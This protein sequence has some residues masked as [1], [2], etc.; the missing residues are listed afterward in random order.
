MI[1]T[2][3]VGKRM[4]NA[5]PGYLNLPSRKIK[6]L[7]NVYIHIYIYTTNHVGLGYLP[8]VGLNFMVNVGKYS[9]HRAYG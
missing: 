6:W 4:E 7:V 1:S 8:T 3:K 9:V 2:L 5:K